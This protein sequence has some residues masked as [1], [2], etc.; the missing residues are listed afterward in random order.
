MRTGEPTAD[1]IGAA[2]GLVIAGAEHLAGRAEAAELRRRL[3][4]TPATVSVPKE[5]AYAYEAVTVEAAR[6]ARVRL[7]LLDRRSGR[8]REALS[9]VDETRRLRIER[10]RR[11]DDA[12]GPLPTGALGGMADVTAWQEGAPPLRLSALVRHVL[13][14]GSPVA[15]AGDILDRWAA[16]G[17][18]APAAGPTAAAA[19]AD[20][21]VPDQVRQAL[22]TVRGAV[23]SGTGV[24][25]GPGRLVVAA[26]PL[27]R[28]D[29]AEIVDARGRDGRALV[30]R[31]A[32]GVALLETS[33]D[34]PF[35]G[36]AKASPGPALLLDLTGDSPALSSGRLLARDG[37]GLLWLADGDGGP[38]DG[39]V[40]VDGLVAGFVDDGGAVLDGGGLRQLLEP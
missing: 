3:A 32:G 14:V 11:P 22:F 12:A 19:A 34:G 26:T 6:A 8:A 30:R 27:G 36:L 20:A 15:D 39:I 7:A 21:I 29:L 33:L 38:A 5:R 18:V 25:I 2:L 10:G 28:S 17:D 35:I 1:L 24:G 23:G 40:L 13:E 9:H 16:V 37:D 31:R 4:A